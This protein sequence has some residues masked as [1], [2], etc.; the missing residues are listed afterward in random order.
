VSRRYA[1]ILGNWIT[2]PINTVRDDHILRKSTAV[3][4]VGFTDWKWFTECMRSGA[5]VHGKQQ[6]RYCG[7]RKPPKKALAGVKQLFSIQQQK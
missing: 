1:Q 5:V 4:R 2:G 7:S 3:A 6:E